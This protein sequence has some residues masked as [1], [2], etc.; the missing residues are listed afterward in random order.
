MEI[1]ENKHLQFKHPFTAMIAGPTGCGKTY[2]L[3]DILRNFKL[4]IYNMEKP[5]LNVLWCHGQMQDLYLKSILNVNFKY[6]YGFPTEEEIFDC[7]IIV[8]DDLM[9]E[10]SKN[11]EILNLFTKGSHHNNKSV[12]FVTQ[13]IFHKGPIMRDLNLNTHYLTIFKNP[14][15]RMQIMCLARQLFP[16]ATKFFLSAF[17]MATENAHGYLFIDLKQDTPDEFRLRSNI[18]PTEGK[19]EYWRPIGYFI[20]KFS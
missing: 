4:L 7:D 13:N 8:V 18:I 12:F 1:V 19:L 10:L 11:K 2:L 5:V 3:R 6:V 16:G 14:R 20:S 9:A 17:N 15:D